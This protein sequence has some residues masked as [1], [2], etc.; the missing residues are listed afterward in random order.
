MKKILFAAVMLSAH[1]LSAQL[2][3]TFY[4]LARK[5]NPTNEVYLATVNPATGLVT[6]VGNTPI[7]SMVNLIG[8]SLDPYNFTYHFLGYNTF[9]SIDLNSGNVVNSATLSA[10]FTPCTFDNFRFNNSDSSLY[11]LARQSYFD[12]TN[13]VY[14]NNMY[15]ATVNTQTG[16]INPISPNSIGMG[17]A[18]AGSAINPYLKVFYYSDGSNLIG[19]DMYTGG[20]YSS[21]PI[22]MTN[23]IAFD[24]FSYNCVDSAIYGLIR[25]NYYDSI[26]DI[27]L[28][29]YVTF[30]D[31]TTIHLGKIDPST[32]VVTTISPFS[33]AQGGYSLNSGSTIDPGTLT[34]Y[35]NNGYELVGVSLQ[36]GLPVSSSALTYSNGQ[37]F[38]LMRIQS[39]CYNAKS[40]IRSNPSNP[41]SIRLVEP[42][43]KNIL[44]PNPA[45]D[46]L[47]IESNGLIRSVVIR[48]MNG[49]VMMQSST[50]NEK[51]LTFHIESLDSGNYLIE[52]N[53]MDGSNERIKWTKFSF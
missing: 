41:S 46:Q 19:L 12:T 6:N 37:F 9:Y 38:E 49:Q 10:P 28:Q 11:G 45:K 21:A 50:K 17:Y 34:Y 18:L 24:N 47:C 48:S 27:T 33:I 4:G 26:W 13:N 30:V 39:N 36:T 22:T 31:S 16:V 51:K 14:V 53:G 1:M 23:G 32:G 20:V 29:Q 2:S 7:T 44:Y 15:L 8:A 52:I 3:N 42:G 43:M 25:Q 5:N 40:P 35:Y